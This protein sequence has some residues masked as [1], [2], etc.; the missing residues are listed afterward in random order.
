MPDLPVAAYQNLLETLE[1]EFTYTFGGC[2]VQRRLSGNYLSQSGQPT[3]DRVN[4]I[5]TDTPYT[6]TQNHSL[7]SAFADELRKRAASALVEE[8]ILVAVVQVYHSE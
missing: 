4:L 6:F 3:Q 7:S 1:A 8:A 2:T 5:Y